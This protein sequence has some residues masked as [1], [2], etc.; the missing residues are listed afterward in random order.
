[1]FGILKSIFGNNEPVKLSELLQQK[2][3]LVDVRSPAEYAS[4][5]VPGSV[6]IP[7]STL[8]SELGRFKNKENIIVFCQSGMRSSQAKSLL[9][10]NGITGVTNAGSWQTVNR[11]MES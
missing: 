6:N 9:E 11:L 8:A 1:M 5:N 7:L 2:A 4:G 3:F 10:K